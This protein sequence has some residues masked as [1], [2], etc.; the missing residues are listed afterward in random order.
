[1]NE[2]DDESSSRAI[3]RRDHDELSDQGWRFIYFWGCTCNPNFK[4][5][6]P[7]ACE[8][9]PNFER[10]IFWTNMVR[11]Q[12]SREIFRPK[13]IFHRPERPFCWFGRPFVGKRGPLVG[14]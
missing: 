2:S 10:T 3:R 9:N 1:M 14:L 6:N 4:K 5:C 11:C 12:V 8:C 13:K 7:N